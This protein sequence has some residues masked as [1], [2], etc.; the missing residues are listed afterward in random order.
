MV[1]VLVPVVVS[2]LA[3]AAEMMMMTVIHGLLVFLLCVLV[4]ARNSVGLEDFHIREM[5]RIRLD[6]QFSEKSVVVY[7]TNSPT[8]CTDNM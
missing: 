8:L 2:I 3:T 7:V 4:F 1:L 5:L 6:Q